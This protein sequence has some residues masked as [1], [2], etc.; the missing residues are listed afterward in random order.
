MAQTKCG[1]RTCRSTTTSGPGIRWS[2]TR[3]AGHS[4]L[5]GAADL[6]GTIVHR[7]RGRTAR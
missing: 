4:G 7:W 5:H 1:G 3:P 2:C 6:A